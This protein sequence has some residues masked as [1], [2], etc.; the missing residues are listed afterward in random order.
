MKVEYGKICA[1]VDECVESPGICDE[2]ENTTCEN[3][4]RSYYCS[5]GDNFVIDKSG[6]CSCK[7]DY[8]YRN[9]G[10]SVW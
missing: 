2:Y 3:N 4:D 6:S 5:C 8:E 9:S 7:P 10:L 1:G